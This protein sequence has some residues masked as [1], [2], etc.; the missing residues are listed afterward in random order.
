MGVR[1][2]MG[3]ARGDVLRLVIREGLALTAAGAAIGVAV[4]FVVVGRL[5]GLLFAVSPRDLSV[6]TLAP[7]TL[8]ASGLLASYIPAR[9]ATRVDPVVALRGE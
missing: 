2:A 8:V 5:S 7:L 3:A 1:M 9:R 4:A 6:F